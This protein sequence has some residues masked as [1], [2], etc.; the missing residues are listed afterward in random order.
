[1]ME[2][3]MLTAA[4]CKAIAGATGAALAVECANTFMDIPRQDIYAALLGAVAGLANMSSTDRAAFAEMP[5]GLWG[6]VRLVSRTLWLA[7]TVAV[8]AL[9]SAW[10]IQI[11][12]HIPVSADL[13]NAVSMA[14]SGVMAWG[15][16]RFLPAFLDRG[17]DTIRGRKDE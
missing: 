3:T 4:K 8:N 5:Q 6:W 14:C 17:S 11:F 10:I 9:L 2:A 12:R 13:V 16:Q 1:M 15:A 7:F